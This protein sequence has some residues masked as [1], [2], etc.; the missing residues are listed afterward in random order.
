MRTSCEEVPT[1]FLVCS[2]IVDNV[3]EK[4]LY[5]KRVFNGHSDALHAYCLNHYYTYEHIVCHN[6][7]TCDLCTCPLVYLHDVVPVF[8]QSVQV[9]VKSSTVQCFYFTNETHIP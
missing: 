6:A 9:G 4:L 7:H 5:H 8:G 1:Q 2:K 3:W